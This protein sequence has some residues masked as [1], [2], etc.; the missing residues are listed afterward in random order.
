MG[1]EIKLDVFEGPL[2]LLLYLIKKN[3]IDIYNIPIALITEQYLDYLDMMRTLNL[4][5]AGEYLILA[6]TLLHIKSKMLLPV[7]EE[8]GEDE[9]DVD[10][11]VELVKQLLEY[12]RYKEAASQLEKRPLLNRDIFTRGCLVDAAS[13][14]E[15]HE[16]SLELNVFDLVEAF[17]KIISTLDKR[18]FLEIDVEKMSLTDRI[19]DI[20]ERLAEKTNITFV[21]LVGEQ[22]SRKVLLYTFLAILELMR[23]RVIRVYQAHAFGVI[24]IRLAVE[25]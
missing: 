6:S 19:N 24:R 9:E 13:G 21:E 7:R 4:D 18:D 20:M 22:G 12:Q 8:D 3:E 1:Y 25:S 23:L 5:L 14:H 17:H 16:M 10:P 15:N 2:D 11:R